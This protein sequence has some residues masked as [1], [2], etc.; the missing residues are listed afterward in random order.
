MMRKLLLLLQINNKQEEKKEEPV[1]LSLRPIDNNGNAIVND[2]NIMTNNNLG[3]QDNVP[4]MQAIT[5]NTLK[6]DDLELLLQYETFL[7][8]RIIKLSIEKNITEHALSLQLGKNG[9][10]I[11]AITNKIALPSV[12]ELFNI[13][14]FFEITPFEFFINLGSENELRTKLYEK[15]RKLPNEDLEKLST[16]L[17]WFE[18]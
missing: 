6:D 14:I 9:S 5:D 8:Q 7:R 15:I 10:Y 17:S 4:V 2:N 12:R 13:M 1:T 3:S 11:R 16:F 18:K